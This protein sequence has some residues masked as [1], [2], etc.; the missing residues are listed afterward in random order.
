MIDRLYDYRFELFLSSQIFI[1]FGTILVP[2]D[3]FEVWIMPIL[4]LCNIASGILLI[5]KK[6]HLFRLFIAFFVIAFVINITGFLEQA[7]NSISNSIKLGS[8]FIFYGIVT[9]EIIH[10]VWKAKVVG[11]NVILG[12]I[13]GFISLGLLSF[14]LCLTIEMFYPNSFSGLIESTGTDMTEQLM[15]YSYITLMTIGYG[16]ILPITPIAQKAAVFIGLIGQFY[17]VILTAIVVGKYIN[18]SSEHSNS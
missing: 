15:Y 18:Q 8:Y 12:L 5:K 4:L 9:I 1:L 6:K 14:F 10:Q 11:K 17:L 16:D 13:S 2:I 3:W 7:V